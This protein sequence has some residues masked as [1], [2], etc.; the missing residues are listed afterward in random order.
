MKLLIPLILF[1][2]LAFY[3]KG[4][5][6]PA[7]RSVDWHQS[8]NRYPFMTIAD[9]VNISDFGAVADAATSNDS[10]FLNALNSLSG[11]AG[12]IFFP[13]GSY[14]FRKSICLPPGILVC[15]ETAS[16]PTLLFRLNA[17]DHLIKICGS[18]TADTSFLT[19]S[20]QKGES[21]IFVY[22]SK[23]FKKAITYSL[24]TTTV[25]LLLPAGL[26]AAQDRFAGLTALRLEPSA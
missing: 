4:Q 8:G 14:F 1:I 18:F 26:I 7:G 24:P 6:L 10:A 19:K 25:S 13:A 16:P 9:T 22:N 21:V 2:S 15:G 23:L 20:V 12:I 5:V 17:G 11:K 3:S